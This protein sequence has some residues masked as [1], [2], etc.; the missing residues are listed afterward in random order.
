MTGSRT[1]PAAVALRPA[2]ALAAG[3]ASAGPEETA[4]GGGPPVGS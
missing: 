2:V 1:G 4:F 3:T